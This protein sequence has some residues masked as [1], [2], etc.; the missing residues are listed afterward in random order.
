MADN[1]LKEL[2]VCIL[3]SVFFNSVVINN[4]RSRVMFLDI[5]VMVDD[6]Q[7]FHLLCYY[8]PC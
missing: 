6:Y 5:L 7:K 2:A 8:V 3:H 4:L 1:T